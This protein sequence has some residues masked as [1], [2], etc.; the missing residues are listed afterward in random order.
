VKKSRKR[1]K[2]ELNLKKQTQF[3]KGRNE[4]KVNYNKEIR[5]IYWIGYLVKTNPIQSQT[6][7]IL[8]SPQI[9]LGVE[10]RF[11]KTNPILKWAK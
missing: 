8:F 11:E 5:E 1:R 6:K 2:F 7:P 9:Y 10:R 4:R 3:S